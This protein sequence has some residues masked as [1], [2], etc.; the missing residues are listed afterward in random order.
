MIN[1]TLFKPRNILLIAAITV[2][3]HVLAKPL[4]NIIDNKA[5]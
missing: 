4:Y 2:A 1:A 5:K 3:T